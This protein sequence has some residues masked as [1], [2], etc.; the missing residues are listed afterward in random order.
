MSIETVHLI[1]CDGDNCGVTVTVDSQA[2][3]LQVL[4]DLYE[5]GWF[6]GW[7][8]SQAKRPGL[9]YCPGHAPDWYTRERAIGQ[10]IGERP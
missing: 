10:E 6:I 7:F 3:E 1:T 5:N 9:T 4:H 8:S 2:R